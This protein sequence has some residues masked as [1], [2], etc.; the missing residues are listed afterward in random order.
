M[1]SLSQNL[2]RTN[3]G[4][5]PGWM[6]YLS[7]APLPPVRSQPL[8]PAYH[9]RALEPDFPLTGWEHWPWGQEGNPQ[10]Q[11]AP[12]TGWMGAIEL[13]HL[14]LGRKRVS[15]VGDSCF[16]L[17]LCLLQDYSPNNSALCLSTPFSRDQ[18]LFW[19]YH[20]QFN[21]TINPNNRPMVCRMRPAAK[22]DC[23][24]GILSL[25]FP[26]LGEIK[27]TCFILTQ[28]AQLLH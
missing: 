9:F 28:Q 27:S 22:W 10:G 21:I 15:P 12:I 14:L 13:W 26:I 1:F 24:P 3:P 20:L 17:C 2:R 23:E 25:S 11:C 6:S 7:E 19:G 18:Y 5:H 4:Q 8:W 16:H